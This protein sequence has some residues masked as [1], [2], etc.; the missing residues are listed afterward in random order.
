VSSRTGT[1]AHHDE[2]GVPEVAKDVTVWRGN[3]CQ[4]CGGRVPRPP[5]LYEMMG[6]TDQL[7]ELILSASAI[8]LKR[9]RT[10]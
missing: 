9:S 5:A 6:M 8:E 4:Y 10:A 1:A 7:R 2:L 3:G